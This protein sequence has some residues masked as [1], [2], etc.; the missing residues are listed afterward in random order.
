[1]TAALTSCAP[2]PRLAWQRKAPART[3]E[4]WAA[5]MLKEAP[6]ECHM[7]TA[8]EASAPLVLLF[9]GRC[10]V[11]EWPT[12]AWGTSAPHNPSRG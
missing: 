7:S 12:P 1:M 2:S 10:L 3:T 11:S 6:L 5:G 4:L 8:Q 9:R